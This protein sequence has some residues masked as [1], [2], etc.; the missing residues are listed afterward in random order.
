MAKKFR[1]SETAKSKKIELEHDNMLL[2]VNSS[3]KDIERLLI[4]NERIPTVEAYLTKEM[5]ALTAAEALG[6][7]LSG[8]YKIVRR[9]QASKGDLGVVVSKKPGPKASL[10]VFEPNME[11][12]IIESLLHYTGKAATIEKVWEQV[13][14]LADGQMNR[15]RFR[16]HLHA[17]N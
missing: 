9:V 11:A 1:K 6:I 13:C 15:P 17:L 7:T 4:G 10:P 2:N 16:R 14:T 12:I 5:N 3:Q 8:F